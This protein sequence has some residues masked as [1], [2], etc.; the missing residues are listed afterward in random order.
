MGMNYLLLN[1]REMTRLAQR[2]NEEDSNIDL[3]LVSAGEEIFT[4]WS[5]LP[6]HGSDHLPCSVLIAK[7]RDKDAPKKKKRVFSYV[8]D[9]TILSRIRRKARAAKIRISRFIQP[10][11]WNE[12]T[13]NAKAKATKNWQKAKR[14]L[15]TKEDE[16]EALKQAMYQ[17]RKDF[18]EIASTAKKEKWEEFA[19]ST[20]GVFTVK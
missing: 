4:Q 14:N 10:P 13:Q 15:N 9:E 5:V 2:D 1:S 19:N 6:S 8:K 16:R 20:A 7:G 17:T 12:E 18:K 11:W 3:A